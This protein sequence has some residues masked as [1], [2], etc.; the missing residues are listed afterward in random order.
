MYL[1]LYI[2]YYIFNNLVNFGLL[3]GCTLNLAQNKRVIV[4]NNQT[5]II[6]EMIFKFE[7]CLP[8][9]HVLYIAIDDDFSLEKDTNS[10]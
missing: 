10:E 9:G 2:C 4:R 3:G 1:E 7:Y 6:Y 5:D 8:K